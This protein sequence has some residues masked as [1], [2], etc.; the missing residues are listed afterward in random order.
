MT[1]NTRA[2][3]LNPILQASPSYGTDK[4]RVIDGLVKTANVLGELIER[5]KTC[6]S[7]R[8]PDKYAEH[9]GE[10]AHLRL[11]EDGRYL[12]ALQMIQTKGRR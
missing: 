5:L 12:E 9:Y 10:R 2:P 11:A 1:T 3:D 8:P 6:T 7:I 4:A